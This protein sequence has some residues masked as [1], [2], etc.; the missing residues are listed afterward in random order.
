MSA[1]AGIEKLK[2][3]PDLNDFDVVHPDPR[4]KINQPIKPANS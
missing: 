4:W 1:W 2:V 3:N